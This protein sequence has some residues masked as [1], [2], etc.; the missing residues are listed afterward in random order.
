VA[1]GSGPFG[2]EVN[3]NT[4][5]AYVSNRDS[6]TVSVI[7]GMPGSP[8]EN[9]VI[10]TLTGFSNNFGIALNPVVPNP[11]RDPSA[12][13]L[14]G[15]EILQCAYIATPPHFSKFAIGGVKALALGGLGGGGG[16]PPIVSLG[17]LITNK[18]FD[19]PDEIAK[20][21][22]NYDPTMAL[23][24]ILTTKFTDFDL[25]LTI[26][27]NG[28]PLAGYSNT[29]KTF[30]TDIGEPI[31]ITSLF[32]EQTV[33]QHVSM[34]L[35]LRGII[36]GDLSQSDTQ[37]L[38]NKDKPLQVIDPNGFFEKVSVNVIEDEDGL[39]KFAEF[40]I[41]FAKPMEQSDIVLR[42]W[43]DKLRSMDTIIYDAIEII[44][45]QTIVETIDP[46]PVEDIIEPV[47]EVQK[48]PDWIKN[49]AE[50]WSQ[51]EVDDTTF[52]NAIG[53]LIQEK[54]IDMPTGPNVSVSTADL[55]V[56]E[57]RALEEE[58]QRVTPIPDWIKNNAEWWYLGDISED[59]FLK[60]V[61]Y[62]VKNGI[63]EI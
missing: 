30:S 40:E 55:T 4:N 48:V 13:V 42:S 54:I 1:V 56:D 17:T 46:E 31:T 11:V 18:N 36:T 34:Y 61:E 2:V 21:V 26:N 29:I 8:T 27:E 32:Y 39:K 3:P 53:F 59:E 41:I 10:E 60:S 20:I 22:E 51:G 15:N 25:P 62:L 14:D 50:W 38:Y 58:A 47:T 6:G 57:K 24:P 45:P 43:N 44:D 7:D 9:T 12:D 19:V 37:I 52:K 33:L 16:S 63:I 35:N 23:K 5:R 49:N 28:Y